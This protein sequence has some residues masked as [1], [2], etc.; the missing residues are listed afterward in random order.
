LFAKRALP[1]CALILVTEITKNNR[2]STAFFG[3]LKISGII[4]AI[5]LKNVDKKPL[6]GVPK[7]LLAAQK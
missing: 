2:H 4:E 5:D 7:E 3:A 6:S 1:S